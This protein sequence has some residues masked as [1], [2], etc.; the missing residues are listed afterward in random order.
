MSFGRSLLSHFIL[1]LTSLL[2]LKEKKRKEKV[3]S[4]TALPYY[5]LAK[6][7]RTD[8]SDIAK[9][10]HTCLYIFYQKSKAVLYIL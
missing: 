1:L 10:F 5:A 2:T 7:S 3:D 6:P 9:T 8:S 4:I